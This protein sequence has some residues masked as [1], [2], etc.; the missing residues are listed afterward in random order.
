MNTHERRT[1]KLA[2]KY[3][4]QK[5]GLRD[6]YG[7]INKLRAI[8]GRAKPDRE[9]MYSIMKAARG[10]LNIVQNIPEDKRRGWV[11]AIKDSV[12]SIQRYGQLGFSILRKR[13]ETDISGILKSMREHVTDMFRHV[14]RARQNQL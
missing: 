10:L 3:G 9:G 14:D 11:R 13:P 4:A 12:E 5:A 7:E 1:I 8:A 6:L 2:M